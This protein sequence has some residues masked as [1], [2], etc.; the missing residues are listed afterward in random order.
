MD[1]PVHT[2]EICA[3]TSIHTKIHFLQLLSYTRN[4]T[5][6]RNMNASKNPLKE[7]QDVTWRPLKIFEGLF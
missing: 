5:C 3:Q 7:L 4:C 1:F 2:N 6:K